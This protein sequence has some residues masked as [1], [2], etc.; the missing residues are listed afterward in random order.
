MM[1]DGKDIWGLNILL[2]IFFLMRVNLFFVVLFFKRNVIY[3]DKFF[4]D[5]YKFLVGENLFNLN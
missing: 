5:D 2:N 1:L 3:F 4:V